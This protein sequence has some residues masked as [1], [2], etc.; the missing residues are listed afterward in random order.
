VALRSDWSSAQCP[1]R[2]GVDVLGDP[3]LL[4]IMRDSLLGLRRFE[5]FRDSLGISESVL[6]RRL[7]SLVDADLLTRQE[8]RGARRT[9]FEYL[10]TEA[11]TDLLPVLHAV[12]RWSE[13]HTPAP[14]GSAHMALVHDVCE[15]ETASAE[16]C[17]NCGAE[18]VSTEDLTWVR[19][20]MHRR[21]KL[22]TPAMHASPDATQ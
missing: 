17:T 4:L 10:P 22:A 12:I 2:R 19:P 13:R 14:P 3:W 20:W 1:V 16:T 6:A 11:G 8:Y 15:R 7:Q 9:H 18:I 5:E 21:D